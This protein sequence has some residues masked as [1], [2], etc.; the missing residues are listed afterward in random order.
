[1][2]AAAQGACFTLMLSH[3][4]TEAGTP[5]LSV[6]T[7]CAATMKVG[8]GFTLISIKINAA[9]PGIT[10]EQLQQAAA[11]AEQRCPV[12]RALSAISSN[13]EAILV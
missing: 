10:E 12:S 4:L 2:I 7:E 13:V 8:T 9:V 11:T 3:V 6:T 5:P 1:M